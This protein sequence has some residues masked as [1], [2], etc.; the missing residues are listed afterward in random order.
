VVHVLGPQREEIARQLAARER[1][2]E[3]AGP[4]LR[5]LEGDA[6]GEELASAQQ[7]LRHDFLEL[8]SG[9]PD[10]SPPRSDR[11][12]RALHAC[13]SGAELPVLRLLFAFSWRA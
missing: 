2:E 11:R 13:R 9:R 10:K 8:L 4:G 6:L 5:L 12:W 1:G 3:P 7:M